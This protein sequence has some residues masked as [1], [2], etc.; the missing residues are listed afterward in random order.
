MGRWG[1]GRCSCS[2]AV[3]IR[4]RM[5]LKAPHP[6]AFLTKAG[7]R[8]SLSF[9]LIFCYLAMHA[10]P[11]PISRPGSPLPVALFVP[12]HHPLGAPS[13]CHTHSTLAST[14]Q[15]LLLEIQL[16]LLLLSHL[17]SPPFPT[18]SHLLSHIL[19]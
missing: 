2:L 11:W 15:L 19:S 3:Y 1:P 14:T 8:S 9:R 6:R 13:V 16:T 10:F 18:P 5:E 7:S 17:G 4:K 12:T